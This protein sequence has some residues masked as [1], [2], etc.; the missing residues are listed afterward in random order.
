MKKENKT[1][2][3]I[4]PFHCEILNFEK[5]LHYLVDVRLC[6]KYPSVNIT[7]HLTFFRSL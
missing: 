7:F 3:L 1:S 2:L 4:T 6:S 5:K